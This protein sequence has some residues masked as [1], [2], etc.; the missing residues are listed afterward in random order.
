MASR[1]LTITVGKENIKISEVEKTSQ[2]NVKV[3]SATTVV[4]PD[5][6][7]DEDGLITDLDMVT[8]AI[9][10]ATTAGGM[11]STE[12]IFVIQSPKVISKEVIT[13]VLKEAKLKDYIKTN[14]AEYFPVNIEEYI[15]SNYILETIKTE[16]T[17]NLKVMAVAVPKM[18]VQ[19]YYE[20]AIALGLTVVSMD[21]S[22]NANS[23]LL[24]WQVDERG[25]VVIQMGEDSTTVC[26]FNNKVPQLIRTVPY[27]RNT[28]ASAV[29]DKRNVTYSDAVWLMTT[30]PILK[31][32]FGEDDYITDS[33]KYLVN[34]IGRVIDYFI[35]K[36]PDVPV[37]TAVFISEEK[38]IMGIELLLKEELNIPVEKIE[39]L[40]EVTL[41]YNLSVAINDLTKYITN[42][43][44]IIHPVNFVTQEAEQATKKSSSGRRLRI[45]IIVTLGIS[46]ILVVFPLV[47]L[48]IST[49]TK[50]ALKSEIKKIEDVKIIVKDYYDAKDRY[51]E[52]AEFK[53][54]A[55]SNNDHVEELIAFLEEEMPSDISVSS[56]NITNGNVT[57]QCTGNSKDTVASFITVLKAR[58]NIDNVFVPSISEQINSDGVRAITYSITY[59]FSEFSDDETAEGEADSED[60]DEEV[61]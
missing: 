10:A 9:S 20:L 21:Y 3:Y 8:N 19:Q 14:A 54:M 31:S 56:L 48:A 26:I 38:P 24:G 4:T 41:E 60:A 29:M 59:S 16:N 35:S 36:N 44:A 15:I 1:I 25:T 32:S 30:K 52:V 6:C 22:N 39:T 51:H 43:G 49:I 5:G 61:E 40:K 28:V 42:I 50:N 23:Q 53:G 33:L 18:M 58:F 2:T 45:A 11:N 57:F 13:P 7:V 27:G 12:A 17:K 34:N 46:V 55:S 47:W 37:E